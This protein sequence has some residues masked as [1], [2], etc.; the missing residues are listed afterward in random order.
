MD[1]V[2]LDEVFS[3]LW[4]MRWWTNRHWVVTSLLAENEVAV[5]RREFS[6]LLFGEAPVP[7][8]YER[9]VQNVRGLGPAG[10]TEILC[11]IAP[12]ETGIWNRRAREALAALGFESCLPVKKYQISGEELELF[13]E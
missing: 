4:S 8:R 9:F 13:N 2:L 11:C 10:V 5:L 1:E 6:E 7:E 3:H 12:K